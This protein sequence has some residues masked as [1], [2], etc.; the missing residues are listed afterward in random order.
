[1][2]TRGRKSA[3]SIAAPV[4]IE[5]RRPSPPAELTEREGEVWRDT[6]GTMPSGWWS[7]AQYPVLVA[8]CRH[9]VRADMLAKQIECFDPECLAV[10]GGPERL[11]KLLGMA[12]RE[13]RAIT[14]CARSMRLTHQ[15]QIQPRGAGRA[16]SG[17]IEGPRP[18]EMR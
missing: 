1:M 5:T 18:W 3:A 10:D 12:E 8:Y 11:N 9:V 14:A 4:L 15:S 17:Q 2:G 13:T 7:R 16:T 6:V